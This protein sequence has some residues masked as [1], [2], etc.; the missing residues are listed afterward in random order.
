[1]QYTRFMMAGMTV[2]FLI[3]IVGCGSSLSPVDQLKDQLRDVP[4]YSII[5]ED[6]KEDG[7]IFTHYFHK[8]KVVQL[9]KSWITGWEE[10]SESFYQKNANFLGMTLAGKK[11]GTASNQVAPPG[12]A[13]VGDSNYGQWRTDSSGGSFWEFYGKYRMFTDV[14]GF[15]SGPVYRHD[16]DDYNRYSTQRRPF[17]GRNNQYGTNGEYT[18]K[19]NPSFFERR[20]ARN[21][22]KKSSFSNRVSSRFGSSDS[23]KIGRT[24]TGFRSRSMGRGK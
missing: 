5:L 6:M 23:S 12:Y 20:M 2:F 7:N 16:Y 3:E 11:D 9:E 24:R 21:Q 10:V 19:H 13:Y 22:Q 8:Y 1:M 17:F 14:L 18:K 4:T 15:M